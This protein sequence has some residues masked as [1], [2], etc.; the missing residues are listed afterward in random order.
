MNTNN[1]IVFMKSAVQHMGQTVGQGLTMKM[2]SCPKYPS[3]HAPICM[4]DTDWQKRKHF[5]EDACC[6]YLLES[7]KPG[8]EAVFRGAGRGELYDA[9]IAAAPSIAA[10]YA[11]IRRNMERARTTGSRM[12]RLTGGM[13]NG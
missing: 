11:P 2:E 10:R 4:L 13:S 7:Q 5:K 1:E 3:C 12:G 8:A 6:F 9:A